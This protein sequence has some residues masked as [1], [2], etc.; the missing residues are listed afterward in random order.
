MM[1]DEKK[2]LELRIWIFRIYE[3]EGEELIFLLK[4]LYIRNGKKKKILVLVTEEI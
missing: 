1:N 2:R 4:K 3:K